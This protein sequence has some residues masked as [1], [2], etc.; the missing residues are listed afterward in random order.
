MAIVFY[1]Y[2]NSVTFN[3]KNIATEHA[4]WEDE[5]EEGDRVLYLDSERGA[6]PLGKVISVSTYREYLL[7]RLASYEMFII[8]KKLPVNEYIV[9]KS[10][11]GKMTDTSGKRYY[12]GRA[13]LLKV[14]WELDPEKGEHL[15]FLWY[16]NDERRLA[17]DIVNL[18]DYNNYKSDDPDGELV[19]HISGRYKIV[20]EDT[21]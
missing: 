16:L 6:R 2:G 3:K 19:S 17:T 5:I 10:D 1:E 21:L 9:L 4:C 15:I 7:V 11:I 14:Y 12:E 8:L 13:T 18:Q 20:S